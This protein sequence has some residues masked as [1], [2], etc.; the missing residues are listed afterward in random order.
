MKI[1]PG[2]WAT[3]AVAGGLTVAV[4][5]T[6]DPAQG[7]GGF[8]S[9]RS[10]ARRVFPT[11]PEA[12]LESATITLTR[13]GEGTVTFAPSPDGHA[14]LLDGAIVGPADPRAVEGLWA[15]LRMA[16]TLRAV[17]ETSGIGVDSLG[18][19]LGRA[20]RSHADAAGRGHEP[21]RRGPLWRDRGP[22]LRSRRAG[23]ADLG[24]RVGD[25]G[26]PRPGA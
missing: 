11:L 2:T 1:R 18:V 17:S 5:A 21:G 22:R 20:G 10:S 24:G 23:G 14:L 6:D 26:H 8:V 7:P 3:L 19:D 15:S 9:T 16:T 25:G 4:H 12:T 13:A